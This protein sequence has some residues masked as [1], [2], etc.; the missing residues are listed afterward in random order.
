MTSVLALGLFLGLAPSGAYAQTQTDQPAQ[1]Q[2][3]TQEPAQ[4]DTQMQ[5]PAQTDTQQAQEPAQTDTQQAQEPAETDTQQAQEP[6]ETDTQQAQEP[7]E[8]DEQQAAAPAEGVI[9]RQEEGSWMGTDLIG[10]TVYSP[11]DE[12]IGDISDLIIME[13]GTVQGVVIGVGG[14]LGIGEKKVGVGLQS[15]SMTED[16]G[17]EMKIVL[18]STKEE[19]EAAADFK[20]LEE[21]RAEQE[22]QQAPATP[23]AGSPTAPATPPAPAD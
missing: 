6:A 1:P 16:E 22:A 12:E 19:L 23:P 9:S 18:N 10:A 20:T 11:Q 3:Q 7:A 5:A 4:T 8:T 17:G 2:A 13:D 21:E 15:L 14:F